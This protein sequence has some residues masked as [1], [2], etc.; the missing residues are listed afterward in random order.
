MPSPMSSVCVALLVSSA[1]AFQLPSV[2]AGPRTCSRRDALFGGAAAALV[3]PAAASASGG[4]TSGKTTSIPRAKLRYYDRISAVVGKFQSMEAAVGTGDVKQAVASFY[5]A[6]YETQDG[7]MSTAFDEFKTAGFLLAVAFK[8]DSKIPPDKIQQ[9]KDFKVLL[10]DLEKL[11][12]AGKPT[13][14]QG[15]Y[16]AAK[17]SMGVFLEGVDLPPLGNERYAV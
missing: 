4:A 9:V 1:A 12:G 6:E 5:K 2:A 11:K 13:E 10:K 15:A 14:A 16:A 8:I 3:G 7:S 17:N